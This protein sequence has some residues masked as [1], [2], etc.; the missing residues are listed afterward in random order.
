MTGT[1]VAKALQIDVNGCMLYRGIAE[2]GWSATFPFDRCPVRGD[3]I[4]I[5]LVSGTH[6]PVM[7]D[8]RTLGIAFAVVELVNE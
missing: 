4:E 8:S 3:T 1:R 2:P 5:D 6:V 7:E